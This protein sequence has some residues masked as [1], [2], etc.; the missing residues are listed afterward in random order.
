[1]GWATFWAILRGRPLGDFF[2]KASGHLAADA[3]KRRQRI[4]LTKE[5]CYDFE[6]IFAGQKWRN[7]SRFLTQNTAF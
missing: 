1:M 7:K 3:I 6:N 2:T 4:V 5:Q